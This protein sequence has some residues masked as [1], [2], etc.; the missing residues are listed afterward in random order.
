MTQQF[1]EHLKAKPV[2]PKAATCSAMEWDQYNKQFLAWSEDLDRLRIDGFKTELQKEVGNQ[3]KEKGF[4]F[5][6]MFL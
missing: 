6:R 3:S 4:S 5:G 1:S 2:R